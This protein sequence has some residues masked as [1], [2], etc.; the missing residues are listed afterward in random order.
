MEGHDTTRPPK[1]VIP[2]V[3]IVLGMAALAA[4]GAIAMDRTG[5]EQRTSDLEKDCIELIDI[6]EREG[7]ISIS[8]L[9]SLGL[10]ESEIIS[11]R[12][13]CIELAP[14]RGK[15]VTIFLPDREDFDS[16]PNASEKSSSRIVLA[17]MNDGSLLPAR[18]E[19]VLRE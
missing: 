10:N 19:V 15:N 14:M 13:A 5:D 16:R 9:S 12:A 2:V 8:S 6:L 3:L 11:G 1:R 18:L 4:G 7:A 17:D